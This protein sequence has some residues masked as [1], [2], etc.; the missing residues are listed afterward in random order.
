MP[1]LGRRWR[2]RSLW[3]VSPSVQGFAYGGFAPEHF[4]PLLAFSLALAARRK[5]LMWTI[6]CAQLLLGVK[7][8][9]AWFLAWFGLIGAIVYDRR[10]G[11]VTL[12]LAVVNGVAYYGIESA[13]GYASEH[14]VY[15]LADREWRRQLAFLAEML[16]PFA[17]APLF[18]GPRLLL[19]LPFLV[20]LFLT[21]DRT[22]AIYRAG[23]YYTEPLVVL[24]AIGTAAVLARRPNFARYAVAGSFLMALFFNPTVLHIGRRPFSHDPQYS[25]ARAWGSLTMAV[26]FPCEDEGA[27]TVAAANVNARLVSCDKPATHER[28][29]WHDDP[30]GSDAAW[31]RGPAT[32]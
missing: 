17:F 26:D 16:V 8:D 4:V 7:E 23:Y 22:Y 13:F 32:P 25:I 29:A 21:Q 24:A 1:A 2:S 12:A 14:P 31:T 11:L 5:S 18:L 28:A 9:Q 20:E 6:V 3:L 10:L 15:G 27:W 30:L 19:A